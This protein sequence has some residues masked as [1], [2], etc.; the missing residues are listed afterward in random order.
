M[1]CTIDRGIGHVWLEGK[2]IFVFGC[3]QMIEASRETKTRL[4][5]GTRKM[6]QT[7]TK[8]NLTYTCVA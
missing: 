2:C 3:I 1:I 5:R 4:R 7:I 8:S 6:A